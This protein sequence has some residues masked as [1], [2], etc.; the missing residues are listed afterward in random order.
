MNRAVERYK[1]LCGSPREENRGKLGVFW[2]TQGCEKGFSMVFLARLLKNRFPGDFTFLIITDREDLDDQIYRNFLH[3]GFM[4]ASE[5]CRPQSSDKLRTMLGED[6]RILFTLIQKFR[7]NK[8][9]KYPILSERDDIIVFIDEAHRTQYKS[10]AENLRAGMP[11]AKYMA[12]TG[13]PLFGSKKLTNKWFGET[14]S[15]YNFSQE[16]Q[17]EANVRLTYRNHLP[18]VQ[19]ENPTFSADFIR[20]LQ[21]EELD[22]D[23]RQRLERRT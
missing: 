8:R 9:K 2:H 5:D 12:F 19:N 23:S 21:D 20:I 6:H 14:V 11:N 15:E 3:S 16:V 17:D 13:T 18:E 22:D 7:Y 1:Y 4:S 10:L